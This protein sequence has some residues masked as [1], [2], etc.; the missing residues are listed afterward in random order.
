MSMADELARKLAAGQGRGSYV[1]QSV[2]SFLKN[3][4][5]LNK[6]E[7]TRYQQAEDQFSQEPDLKGT[8]LCVIKKCR[9]EKCEDPL[10]PELERQAMQQIE[11]YLKDL[12][13]Q[14]VV[15]PTVVSS[16]APPP[17]LLPTKDSQLQKTKM[18]TSQTS[19]APANTGG[20]REAMLASIQSFGR[21]GKLR[22]VASD[23]N[24]TSS[25]ED[26]AGGEKNPVLQKARK[27][28][29]KGVADESSGKLSEAMQKIVDNAVENFSKLKDERLNTQ[30]KWN[31][32]VYEKAKELWVED[33]ESSDD[34]DVL[35]E[36]QK[37]L[38]LQEKDQITV[39]DEDAKKLFGDAFGQQSVLSFMWP[40][41]KRT[42][43][44]MRK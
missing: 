15:A 26:F 43:H 4:F 16:N 25:G 31:W 36:M 34:D 33:A 5:G 42:K 14:S 24:V 22:S 9:N 37:E 1:Q 7:R 29:R 8:I 41:S 3:M 35:D 13:K 27:Q 10:N 6:H 32:A 19:K 23:K 12:Q 11:Q 30:E 44:L 39:S 18:A 21:E 2:G 40:K 20:G 28:I 38:N 17:P